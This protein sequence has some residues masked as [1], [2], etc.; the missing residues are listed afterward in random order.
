MPPKTVSVTGFKN[1]GKTSV[2][3]ALVREL[4]S[5]GRRFGTLNHTADDIDLDTPGKDTSRHRDAGCVA[6]GILQ[7]NTT[8]LFIDEKLSIHQ[9]AEKL[10][11][12]DYLVIEGFK[13]VDTHARIIVPRE[14]GDI[15]KLS[16]G[17]E[18]ATV[19][20]PG[21]KYTGEALTLDDAAKIADIVEERVY[22]MLPGFDCHSCG[23]DDCKS[24]GAAL[25]AGE[26]ELNQCVGYR[27]NGVLK[28]NGM[29]VTMGNFVREI[30]KNVVLGFVKTL[31]GREVARKVELS[32]E[33]NEDE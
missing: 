7:E 25:L 5:R 27:S 9:A 15:E 3:E 12:I 22:P 29:E 17:L 14:D 32:F 26:A 23:H 21:S 28:V 30:M 19:M 2:V 6:T 1:S 16:N 24:M 18:I 4:S 31:K 20:I 10:G 8:A 33:V 13:T 11:A